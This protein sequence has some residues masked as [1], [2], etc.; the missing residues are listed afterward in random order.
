VAVVRILLRAGADPNQASTDES[1]QSP[2]MQ[3]SARGFV[4]I[5]DE[6]ISAGAN[7]NYAIP[8]NG[9]TSL[10]IAA[11]QGFVDVVRSLLAAGADPRTAKHDGLT[12]LDLALRFNH[13]AIAALLE[14][15]IAELSEST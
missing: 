12:A 14:A 2:L 9:F 10:M 11:I 4:Q 7:I 3:A 6:L 15:K 5:V 1:A 8:N 13:T